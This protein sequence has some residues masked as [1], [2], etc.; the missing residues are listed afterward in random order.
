MQGELEHHTS[1]GRFIRT[2]QKAY[3]LQLAAIERWQAHIHRIRMKRDVLNLTDV[4]PNN[5]DEHHVIGASQ[6]FPEE[7]TRFVQSNIND[8][9]TKASI[10]SPHS[11][12][13]NSCSTTKISFWS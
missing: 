10:L 4:V 7:L 13:P 9:A 12:Q 11:G 2:S 1:K 5:A 8:P 6:N 3:V